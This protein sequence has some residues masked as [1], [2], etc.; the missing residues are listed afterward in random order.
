MIA[1]LSLM[2]CTPCPP[3]FDSIPVGEYSVEPDSIP[4][5]LETDEITVVVTDTSV[6]LSYVTQTGEAVN[7]RYAITSGTPDP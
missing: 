4:D 3:R 7:V 1:F 5:L 2:A 6:T